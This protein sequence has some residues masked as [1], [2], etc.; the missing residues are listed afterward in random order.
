M[1]CQHDWKYFWI[2]PNGYE[3]DG[4]LITRRKCKIC[5]REYELFE[6]DGIYKNR[7]RRIN[8]E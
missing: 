3:Y 5:G 7:W 8:G 6:G 4:A 2:Y 1:E